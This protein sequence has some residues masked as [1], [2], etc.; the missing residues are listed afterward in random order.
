MPG[1]RV[2]SEQPIDLGMLR[3]W[4]IG[5]WTIEREIS[6][7]DQ[8]L[9]GSASF[10]SKG[11]SLYYRENLKFP[12]EEGRELNAWREYIYDFS[13]TGL[14]IYFATNAQRAELFMRPKLKLEE[15]GLKITG[16]SQHSCAPDNYMGKFSFSPTELVIEFTVK[17][18]RKDYSIISH[19]RKVS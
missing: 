5:S 14:E 7:L 10:T 18:P 12:T 11:S 1:V 8:R 17:G 3:N 13:E 6:V 19:C 9:T 4:L 16:D 2:D 15:G